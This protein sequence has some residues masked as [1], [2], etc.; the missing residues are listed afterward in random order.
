LNHYQELAQRTAK[1]DMPIEKR[2]AVGALGLVGEAG[3]TAELFKKK[4]GHGH[5]LSREKVV[6]ELGDV[7]WYVAEVCSIMGVSLQEVA[8]E[9]IKKLEQRYPEGFNE[10]KSLHRIENDQI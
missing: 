6:K 3:E 4:L 7:M 5:P 10:E 8:N 1:H 2:M 9:N